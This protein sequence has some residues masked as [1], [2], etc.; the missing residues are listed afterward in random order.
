MART[1]THRTMW[2][3][4]AKQSR[5]FHLSRVFS[6]VRAAVEMLRRMERVG[7]GLYRIEP[8]LVLKARE[9]MDIALPYLED[10]DGRVEL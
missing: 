5:T 2:K 8:A 9:Q 7:A 3:D 6:A 1:A 4:G 10:M